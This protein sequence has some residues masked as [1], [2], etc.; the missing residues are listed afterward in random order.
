[1]QK[2]DLWNTDQF[3]IVPKETEDPKNKKVDDD[4]NKKNVGDKNKNDADDTPRPEGAEVGGEDTRKRK[5]PTFATYFRVLLDGAVV[6]IRIT[7]ESM[8]LAVLLAMPICLSRMYGPAPLRWLAVA[9]VEFFRGIPVLFLLYFGYFGL[10][11]LGKKLDND[12]VAEMFILHAEIVAVIAFGLNYAAYEAEVYRA[13]IGA[14]PVGQWEASASLGMTPFQSFWRI[15]LPQ[16]VR[17][18]LPPMTNDLV[19]LF[20]DTSLV[21]AITIVELS[22]EYRNLNRDNDGY[23]PIALT[24][25]ALYLLMSVPLGYL[26]RYLEKRWGTK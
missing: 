1:M 2:W 3:E 26:S 22:Q 16:S 5:N 20:K 13:A 24:T 8:L 18:I 11:L 23:L 15:I 7:F 25:A 19:S 4:K 12:D 17:G 6:T 21:S 9:Y 14:V 10:P